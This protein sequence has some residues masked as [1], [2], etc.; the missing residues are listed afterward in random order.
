MSRLE[1]NKVAADAYEPW[2]AE[3]QANYQALA[4]RFKAMG[5]LLG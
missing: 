5:A 3:Y 2:F 4:P 1:P